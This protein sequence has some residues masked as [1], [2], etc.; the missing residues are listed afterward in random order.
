MSVSRILTFIKYMLM[1]LLVLSFTCCNLTYTVRNQHNALE[2]IM[3]FPC[4]RV[5]LKLNGKGNSK[6]VLNQQFVLDNKIV[7]CPDSIR[8]FFN[9]DRILP[10]INHKNGNARSS[11][12]L[13]LMETKL[14]ETSFELDES[15][16]EGDT[17]RIFA[18]GYI[19]CN[20]Q[21]LNLDTIIYSFVNNI[22]IYGVND[23]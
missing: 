20:G 17:I 9:D 12:N 4:G 2:D 21:V 18:P 7:V 10:I 8:I 6:F 19:H 16:F 23:F 15:V 13:E 14:F 5:I 3:H 11:G 22:R 1:A